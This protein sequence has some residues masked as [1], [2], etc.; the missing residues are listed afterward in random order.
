MVRQERPAQNIAVK[1]Y[2]QGSRK[3]GTQSRGI[4]S[5]TRKWWK[6][7][8]LTETVWGSQDDQEYGLIFFS[9][10]TNAVLVLQWKAV[11]SV[12]LL[13]HRNCCTTAHVATTL[14][15]ALSGDPLSF[16][17]S[18]CFSMSLL[19]LSNSSIIVRTE[20]SQGQTFQSVS[21]F[22]LSTYYVILQKLTVKSTCPSR[23]ITDKPITSLSFALI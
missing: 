13:C 23:N 10:S 8:C 1:Y 22:V 21:K 20:K 2:S 16:F 15:K 11:L 5:R 17:P 4:A 18:H 19:L 9:I 7:I 6:K 12:M 3:K 14:H